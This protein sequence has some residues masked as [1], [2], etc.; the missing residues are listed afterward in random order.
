MISGARGD[1][2]L[3]LTQ[4]GAVGGFFKARLSFPEDYPHGPPTMR[5]E[6][7]IWHPNSMTC[8]VLDGLG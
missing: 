8:A 2:R 1:G 7:P 3:I 4:N 6:T 5:F